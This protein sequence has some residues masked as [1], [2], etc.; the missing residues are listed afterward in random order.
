MRIQWNG[1]AILGLIL[2][3]LALLSIVL[4]GA[5]IVQIWVLRDPVTQDA[6]NTLDLLNSTLDT[7][8]VG[9]G[10]AKS[11]LQSVTTTIGAL[12][13][14]VQS[15]AVTI[16]SASTSVSS[17]SDVIGK[18]LSSTV[19]SAL[20]TLDAVESTT[21]T[22]DEVLGGLATLPFLNIKYDPAKPLSASVSDLTDQLKQ[23]PESLDSLQKNLSDSGTSL[24][25]VSTDANNLA[26]S[27]ASVQTQMG[28]LVGVIDQY[29]TQV[30][31]FQGTVRN[32]RENIVT[33]AWGI[34]LF[35]TFILFWLGVTMVQTLW[36]GL[37]WMGIAP[38]W[39]DAPQSEELSKLN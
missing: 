22:I 14:T 16:D 20:G 34:T 21:K 23:V 11:S 3:I 36:G 38:H 33:I 1:R 7:T 24:N 32:V 19:N 27:L 12:Q 25:K 17:V 31:A 8:S 30:K 13:A 26:T 10:V 6:I 15:A 2:A 29:Q 9:L 39:F 35:L 28:Q 37:V 18:N 4:D 5:G